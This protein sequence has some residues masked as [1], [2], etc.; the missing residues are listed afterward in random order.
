MSK[1]RCILHLAQAETR[2]AR[3]TLGFCIL[4][5]A[6]GV[7]AITLIL[8][9]AEG[10]GKG[11]AKQAQ[12]LMGGD[13]I[14]SAN[15]PLDTG[16]AAELSQEL[17]ELGAR[18]ALSVRFLS[19]LRR[20]PFDSPTG[21]QAA[22]RDSQLVRL[23]AT[24]REF[25]LRG[26]IESSPPGQYARLGDKPSVL[27][28]P[29]IARTL[30]LSAGD[31]VQIG[32]L[33]ATVLGQFSKTPGSPAAR[34]SMAP[35]I[36]LDERFLTQTG[37][38]AQGSRIRYERVFALPAGQDA[39]AW[40]REHWQQAR[41]AHLQLKT[42]DETGSSLERLA[43]FLTVVALVT[44]F[45][46]ALGVGSG[47]QTFMTRKLNNAAILRS[48]GATSGDVVGVYGLLTVGVATLGGLLGVTLGSLLP[49]LLGEFSQ[50]FGGDFLPIDLKLGPSPTAMARGM[51]TGL[52][53]ATAFSLLPV[54]RTAH[55]S[56][57]RVL[58]GQAADG[59]KEMSEGSP[60]SK[61]RLRQRIV[62]AVIFL[63]LLAA[64][65]WTV[66]DSHSRLLSIGFTVAIAG[67][68]LALSLM[69]WGVISVARKFS[70]K[71]QSF[72]FRQGIA[73]LH[74]PGNQTR[75]VMVALG[76]GFLL[77]GTLLILQRSLESTL[78]MGDGKQLPNFFIIEA[79]K[80][81]TEEIQSLLNSASAKNIKRSPMISA[82]IDSLNGQSVTSG[83][84]PSNVRDRDR[85]ERMKTREYFVSHREHLVAS[86]T[87]VAGKFWPQNP[88][89]Q[90]ISLDIRVADAIGAHLGDTLTLDVQGRPLDGLVTSF[91]EIQWLSLRPNAMILLSPGPIEKA[92]SMLVFSSTITDASE[93]HRLQDTLSS[94]FSN[95]TVIDAEEAAE[96]ALMIVTKVARILHILGLMA[97]VAGALVFAGAIAAGRFAREREAMLLK[98]LGAS[99]A[100]LR[101]ILVAEYLCLAL[102]GVSCGWMLSEALNRIAVKA[103]FAVN[104]HP[105]Y[106]LLALLALSVVI[107]NV[108]VA[109]WVGRRVS[110][111]P[112]LTILRG[113]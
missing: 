22:P 74:R 106:E 105:P 73:N 80:E 109:R 81:Q 3:G 84:S 40:K 5:V 97:V 93:R 68:W 110:N 41:Q 20:L 57:L 30:G 87:I 19:M 112:P 64:V 92:P 50:S 82:R 25:P 33:V 77:L 26:K 1:I 101:R 89:R 24:S 107:L 13:L 58:N 51:L 37:L 53:S 11:V 48:L 76:M 96:S 63:V 9:L 88:K 2:R 21:A 67:A 38:V 35:F 15:H 47:L 16:L 23:R 66:S 103:L 43:G 45:L 6:M 85:A 42:F 69:A 12:Q 90:E 94:R 75:S 79:H 113:V 52:L 17:H 31:S 59:G 108:G 29:G 7:M 98:V 10:M 62:L 83:T 46:G 72:H 4:S 8:S 65:V 60:G 36:Y 44:L 39:I 28:D 102:L 55:V 27:V 70:P 34:F 100:D 91:R 99:R 95:L 71:L 104:A 56:P 49:V 14:L 32:D 54:W 86:E 111:T 61:P 18:S 78:T